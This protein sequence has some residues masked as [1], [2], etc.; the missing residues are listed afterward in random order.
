[1]LT[2]REQVWWDVASRCPEFK[3]EYDTAGNYH[4]VREIV[5]G[6]SIPWA[7]FHKRFT[8]KPGMRVMDV[9]ANAGIFSAYCAAKGAKVFAYEPFDVAF[10]L[11]SKIPLPII[12]MKAAI[13]TH[14]GARMYLGNSS[15]LEDSPAYNGSLQ[16]DG[17]NWNEGD[18]QRAALVSC[19]SLDDAVADMEWDCMKMDIEGAECDV[20]LAASLDTLRRI[21][22]AYVEFHPWV[23]ETLY[24]ECVARME[25]VYKFEI[26][27]WNSDIGRCEAAYLTL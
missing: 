19:L 13:W 15:V 17:I 24:K 5:L 12:P 16:T 7:G 18:K 1:M 27:Y 22:F 4:A 23:N 10:A 26:A 25:S 9:G 6:G 8:P 20:L 21:K 2:E 3:P 14:S 11:L